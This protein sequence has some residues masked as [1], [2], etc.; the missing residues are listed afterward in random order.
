MLESNFL[1]LNENKSEVIVFGEPDHAIDLGV[2]H[3]F[4]VKNLGLMIESSSKEI[5]KSAQW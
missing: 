3:S 4:C 2:P 1:K 5:S